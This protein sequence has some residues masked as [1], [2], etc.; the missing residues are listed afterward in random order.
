M[1]HAL[2]CILRNQKHARDRFPAALGGAAVYLIANGE[3]AAAVSTAPDSYG[4]AKALWAKDH[5]RVVHA[6]HRIFTV[7]PIRYGCSFETEAQVLA[8]LHEHRSQF[9]TSLRELEGCEEMGLRILCCEK[10]EPPPEARTCSATPLTGTAYLASR[11]ALYAARDREGKEAFQIIERI[12]QG[13]DGLFLK[14][15][16]ERSAAGKVQLLSL[17]FLVRRESTER[18]RSAFRHMKGRVPE[19]L[20]LTG[21]WPLYNFSVCEKIPRV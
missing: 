9:Q 7:L 19:R 5:A 16:A 17:H 2:Y 11:R 4:P 14:C 12:R 20:L 3:L 6:L 15:N 18:F 10:R 1:K 13:F 21:P 8:L